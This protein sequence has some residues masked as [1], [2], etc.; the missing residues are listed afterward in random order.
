MLITVLRAADPRAFRRPLERYKD[1]S[2]ESQHSVSRLAYGGLP[3]FGMPQ[4]CLIVNFDVS[5]PLGHAFWFEALHLR[6]CREATGDAAAGLAEDIRGNRSVFLE[7][8]LTF[9]TVLQNCVQCFDL[10]FSLMKN[11]L[12]LYWALL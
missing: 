11:S 1:R 5:I 10:A 9:G 6:S 12:R 2:Q 4:F 3:K 8:G 7:W